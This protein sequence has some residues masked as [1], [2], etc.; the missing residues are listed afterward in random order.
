MKV[1]PAT[2]ISCRLRRKTSKPVQGVAPRR[3]GSARGCLSAG[4]GRTR[5]IHLQSHGLGLSIS[6]AGIRV[7]RQPQF[8]ARTR[9]SEGL[10]GGGRGASRR[11]LVGSDVAFEK[12]PR[13]NLNPNPKCTRCGQS[14]VTAL[15]TRRSWLQG[16]RTLLRNAAL[17]SPTPGPYAAPSTP[18][19]DTSFPFADTYANAPLGASTRLRPYSAIQVALVRSCNHLSLPLNLAQAL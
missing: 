10:R 17:P 14:Q 2:L 11:S 6:K 12:R 15:K 16:L 18:E 13:G 3:A 7:Q 4:S 1:L 8:G 5:V 19:Y 9:R